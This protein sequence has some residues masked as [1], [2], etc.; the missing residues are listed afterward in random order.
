QQGLD[1]CEKTLGLYGVLEHDNW[2][3]NPDWQRLNPEDRRQL[4][5]GTRELLLLLAGGRVR[6]A[7]G[8]VSPPGHC[9]PAV[10][11]DALTVL[12]RDELVRGL[13]ESPALLHDRA[14]YLDLLGE[15]A[16]ARITRTLAER[17]QPRS[18]RDHYLLAA[19]YIR[20]GGAANDKQAIAELNE[21]VRCNPR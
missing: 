9:P 18:A 1:L 16:A 11:R 8:Q 14:S 19:A 3:D 5:E 2:E 15:T 4:A 20:K 12:D 13:N 6:K 10:L 7:R 17:V 21:A